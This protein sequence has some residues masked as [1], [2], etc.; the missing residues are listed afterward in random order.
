MIDTV[1]PAE[2]QR[3]AKVA[4]SW[5]D[6][7]GPFRPLHRFNPVRLEVL[8]ARLTAHFGRDP[9][10][11]KPFSGLRLLDIGCGGGL[12][13]EP[14]ARLGAQVVGV[15]ATADNVK[16]ARAHAEASG[17]AIDYRYDT[18]E[19]LLAAGERFDAVLA[20]EI[21]EH[22][23]DRA[24]FVGACAGLTKP[25][26]A[27]LFSTLNRTPRAFGMAILGAEYLLRWV[28]RGTHEWKKFVKPSEL[29]AELRGAGLTLAELIGLTYEPLGQAWSL[30][31]DLSVN[32]MAY[33][34]KPGA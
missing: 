13:A 15:D 34:R 4:E 9:R 10:S 32:Y 7:E 23:A 22:V 2:I 17:L 33:A 8:R 11:L 19:G 6:T 14:M 3:F 27:L 18:A 20:L 30:G 29:A 16:I 28:P 12:I 5:W 1:D 31:R 21:V 24:G 25:G 26:G